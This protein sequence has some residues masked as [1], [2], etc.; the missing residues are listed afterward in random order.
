[1]KVLTRAIAMVVSFSEGVMLCSYSFSVILL[2]YSSNLVKFKG[3]VT[4]LK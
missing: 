4:R 2:L 3:S 1:M